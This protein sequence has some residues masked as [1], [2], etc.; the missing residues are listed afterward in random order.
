MKLHLPLSLFR[1][2]VC[3]VLSFSCGTATLVG[4]SLALSPTSMAAALLYDASGHQCTATSTVYGGVFSVPDE[5]PFVLSG[6]SSVT[7]NQNELLTTYDVYGGVVSNYVSGSGLGNGVPVA[8]KRVTLSG[9]GDICFAHNLVSSSKSVRVFGGALY[10]GGETSD[11]ESYATLSGNSKVI[12]EDN[13]IQT[14]GRGYGAAIYNMS[15]NHRLLLNDND[16]LLFVNN[17]I[18][19]YEAVGGALFG[20]GEEEICGNKLVAFRQ[21]HIVGQCTSNTSYDVQGGLSIWQ[22][23]CL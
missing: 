21:N 23:V 22:R 2:L 6:Y 14:S 8:G 11:R 5:E 10:N 4:A 20:A 1:A 18:E 7:L 15:G 16:E 3:A 17:T 12:F 13:A 9:N 19:A